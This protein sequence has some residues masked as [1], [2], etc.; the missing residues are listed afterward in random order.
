[1]S[2]ELSV[3]V[4]TRHQELL[5]EAAHNHLVRQLADCEPA[6]LIDRLRNQWSRLQMIGVKRQ[7]APVLQPDTLV[8]CAAC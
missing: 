6:G 8:C 4:E 7:P 2:F 1:M 3:L 5:R